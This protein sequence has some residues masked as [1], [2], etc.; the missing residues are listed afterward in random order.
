MAAPGLD[1]NKVTSQS[2]ENTRV[3]PGGPLPQTP[4]LPRF[5]RFHK[6][7]HGR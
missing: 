4:F 2:S 3:K 6:K 7:L 1:F 5:E